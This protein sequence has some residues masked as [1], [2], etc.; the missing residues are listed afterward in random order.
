M[1]SEGTANTL[2]ANGFTARNKCILV[3]AQG[4]PSN[5]V[6]GWLKRIQDQL[7]IPIYFLVILMPYTMQN[8]LEP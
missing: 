5:A 6:R 7:K 1:E 2:V 3:G 4:V 8:I